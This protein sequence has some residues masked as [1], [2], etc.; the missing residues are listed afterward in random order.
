MIFLDAEDV[1]LMGVK[2]YLGTQAENES[3][4]IRPVCMAFYH[5]SSDFM[6]FESS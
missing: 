6:V 5:T 2:M 1:L 3:E 4:G